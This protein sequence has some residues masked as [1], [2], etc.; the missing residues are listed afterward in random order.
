MATMTPGTNPQLLWLYFSKKLLTVLDQT[1][2]LYPLGMKT[3]MP[4]GMGTQAK[5]VRYSRLNAATT[6]LT[7]GVPP[8]ETSLVTTNVTANISQY[9]EFIKIADLLEMTAIDSVVKGALE[10]L[11]K[12]GSLTIDTLCRNELDANLPSQFCNNKTSLATTGATDVFTAKEVL[13]AVITLR[14]NLV[15]PHTGSD[16]ICVAHSA[17]LGDLKN[18]TNIGSWVDL[19]KYIEPGKMRPFTGEA[20]KV[21][22]ARILESQNIS[23]TTVGTLLG[24]EVYSNLLLG[25]ECFGVVELDGKSVETFVKPQGSAG[26]LDPLNQVGTVGWKAVGFAAKYLGGV[27]AG[28]S[29]LGIR[30]RGGS[31]Y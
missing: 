30:I 31:A 19:N 22:G 28:T 4:K 12:Q 14:K 18:D 23:S 3:K 11:G 10:R 21:Y 17:A 16:F 24:A 25:E 8:T 2:Q 9:G 7:V 5:W 29:D 1:L 27:A 6:P 26:S 20:G 15:G 13:K